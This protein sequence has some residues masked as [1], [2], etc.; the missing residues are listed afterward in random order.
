[1]NE[2]HYRIAFVTGYNL[3]FGGGGE[4]V[5]LEL[6]S[7]LPIDT[8]EA[9]IVQT[10]H[11]DRERI[12]DE[13][14]KAKCNNAE[15]I[16]IRG[17]FHK[18]DFLSKSSGLNLIKTVVIFPLLKALSAIRNRKLMATISNFD[19]VYLI[20]NKLD[21][22]F[23]KKCTLLIGSAHGEFFYTDGIIPK[24]QMRLVKDRIF[25]RAIDGFHL[26][27]TYKPISEAL[28]RKFN[29][30]LPNGTNPK[31]NLARNEQ[32][33]Q[34]EKMKFL[35]VGRLEEYKG[36]ITLV[37][38]W[39]ELIPYECELHIVGV[40][41]LQGWIEENNVDGL[42]FHG[43]VNASELL[44]ITKLCDVFIYP[45]KRDA[46]PLVI[47]DALSC[48]LYVITSDVLAGRFDDF[49]ERGFL[50]YVIPETKLLEV[51]ITEALKNKNELRL[52][53]RVIAEYTRD[54]YN[55][56]AIASKFFDTMKKFLET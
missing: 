22:L 9:A 4:R 42:Y 20:D 17:Y 23:R 1:M 55:W 25:R 46:F 27:P 44:N 31:L 50:K 2:L 21:T 28:G 6:V 41:P 14:I 52:K 24:L 13:E 29:F 33:E 10:D 11:I 8:F 34:D 26:F 32:D 36:V 40:G 54:N 38:A 53:R 12:D 5:I 16:T 19:A 30:I 47:I 48:G 56:D 3:R 37:E 49:L 43:L 15:L 35:F 45:T 39:K 51:A 7:R 18:F